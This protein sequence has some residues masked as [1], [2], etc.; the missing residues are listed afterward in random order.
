MLKI[1]G[2]EEFTKW[3]SRWVARIDLGRVVPKHS[4]T[5]KKTTADLERSVDGERN[6]PA[7]KQGSQRVQWRCYNST[8]Q[9]QQG[10]LG[11][12]ECVS[13]RSR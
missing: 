6:N 7:H 2:Q 8:R 12:G 9:S 4:P 1:K 13:E 10:V 3:W 5:G 11:G